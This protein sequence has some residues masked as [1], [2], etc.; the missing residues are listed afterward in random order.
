MDVTMEDISDQTLVEEDS[1]DSGI[2]VCY[3]SGQ[4]TDFS[5]AEQSLFDSHMEENFLS[6]TICGLCEEELRVETELRNR[7]NMD[8]APCTTHHGLSDITN[9]QIT[10]D[11]SP[12]CRSRFYIE[13]RQAHQE[14]V[15]RRRHLL[16][17][18]Q[19]SDPNDC[20]G[21][22]HSQQSKIIDCIMEDSENEPPSDASHLSYKNKIRSQSV[23]TFEISHRHCSVEN[24]LPD[25]LHV[26]YTLPTLLKPQIDSTAFRSIDGS[27]LA[28]MLESLSDVEFFSRFLLV[29][30]RYPYEYNGGHI[31]RAVNMF[32]PSLIQEYFFPEYR[33]EFE[34]I[35]KRIPIF[36]C[37]YSQKRGPSMA[38][39]LREFDRKR[40]EANYPDVDYKE[41]YV[42]DRGYKFFY[43]DSQH[44]HL[45]EPSSYTRMVD[46]L[47]KNELKTYQMHRTKSFCGI[48]S[49]LR[50]IHNEYGPRRMKL[51]FRS[52]SE[53]VSPSQ[54]RRDLFCVSTAVS[55]P[56]T[57]PSTSYSPIP[58]AKF[59]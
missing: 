56:I 51:S 24:W 59:S 52:M 9:R 36:Y 31:K 38:H 26:T 7:H 32:D 43:E 39:A 13:R 23:S 17:T 20:I 44:Q 55:A 21:Y 5:A 22:T 49:C 15:S 27:I 10:D 54:V 4:R 33:P 16:V 50:T 1:R 25:N 57:P 3:D 41:I 42:L 19:S 2:S 48:G 18:S 6:E 47:Y 45:C 58:M 30:C 46:P 29:D 40:N 28:Q 37:E 8:A 34:R 53:N 12:K 14:K 35:R 11:E